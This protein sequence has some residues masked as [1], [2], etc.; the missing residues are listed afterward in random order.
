MKRILSWDVGIKNLAGCII[1]HNI[2]NI[3]QPYEIE[4]WNVIDLLNEKDIICSHIDNKNKPCCAK[5]KFTNT[6]FNNRYHY[7]G[8]HVKQFK[9]VQD[10]LKFVNIKTDNKCQFCDSVAKIKCNYKDKDIFLCTQHKNKCLK[11][12]KLINVKQPTIKDVDIDKLKYNLWILL[13]KIPE[14]LNVDEVIIE[15]QP[16]LKN[17]KMKAIAETLYNY[18]LCRGIID[19]KITMSPISKVKY[20]SPSNKLK[21]NKDNTKIVLSNSKNKTDT[22]K[23]TKEL[24][25]QYCY[26]FIQDS[27]PQWKSYLDK[28]KKKDDLCDSLLQGLYYLMTLTK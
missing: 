25:I 6:F 10:T 27:M 3:E 18:F 21:I 19:T 11:D 8:V 7:C 24:G 26:Q 23:L 15:N 22:Y 12:M 14:L 17:P 4:W 20:V 13:D 28:H 5:A 2:L 9:K 16:S 1:H